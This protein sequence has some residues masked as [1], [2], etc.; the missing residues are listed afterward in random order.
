MDRESERGGGES[1][2]RFHKAL[3]ITMLWIFIAPDFLIKLHSL[4]TP[5]QTHF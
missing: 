2:V 1:K 4:P 5:N 3:T